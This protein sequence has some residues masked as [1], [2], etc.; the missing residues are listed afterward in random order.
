MLHLGLRQMPRNRCASEG[1]E[2][3]NQRRPT[4]EMKKIHASEADA[5]KVQHTTQGSSL[6]LVLL[7]LRMFIYNLGHTSTCMRLWKLKTLVRAF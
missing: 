2:E 6:A 1:K 4:E 7:G 3:E 5:Q